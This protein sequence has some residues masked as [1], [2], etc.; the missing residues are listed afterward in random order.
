MLWTIVHRQCFND[1]PAS[2]GVDPRARPRIGPEQVLSSFCSN[3]TTNFSTSEYWSAE[4]PGI[5]SDVCPQLDALPLPLF[6]LLD[7]LDQCFSPSLSNPE[8]LPPLTHTLPD[9]PSSL[10]VPLAAILLDFSVGYIP[11][12]ATTASGSANTSSGVLLHFFECILNYREGEE[13]E[14][15]FSHASNVSGKVINQKIDH[16]DVKSCSVMK[17]SCPASNQISLQPDKIINHLEDL[18]T[19]R[20][21]STGD[22]TLL[23]VEIRQTTDTLDRLVLWWQYLRVYID[24]DNF[25]ILIWF[26][27]LISL[28]IL[29]RMHNLQPTYYP[30]EDGVLLIEPRRSVGR[31]EELGT[32]GT[33][34]SVRHADCIGTIVRVSNDSWKS[35]EKTN[36]SWLTSSEISS[37]NS[38][39]QIDIPP[40]PS[41]SG[42]PV[43]I[44]N[45]GIT[46]WKITPSKYPLLAWPTKFSTAFGACWGNRFIWMSPTVVWIVAELERWERPLRE[47]R[48]VEATVCS[49]LVGRSLKTSRSLDF[50][51]LWRFS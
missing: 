14:V 44:M 29:D 48:L 7:S 42:S 25:N 12:L 32:I 43:W 38:L 1:P 49:S 20:L 6:Q 26:I 21:I 4:F 30:S 35:R 50:W 46:L 34:S 51:S 47:L 31:D 16:D 17:F 2:L 37:S 19:K 9:L 33:R 24:I 5:D 3:I 27:I 10:S 41:P 18:F 36:R 45:L 23:K 13:A 8:I 40:V 11:E 22:P 15:E 28:H 39:P